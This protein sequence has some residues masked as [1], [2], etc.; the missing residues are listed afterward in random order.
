MQGTGGNYE[1]TVNGEKLILY[2]GYTNNKI[3]FVEG[4]SYT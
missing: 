3:L 1:V 2:N 4:F